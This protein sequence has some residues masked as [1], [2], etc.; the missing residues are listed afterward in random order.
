MTKILKILSDRY[1]RDSD[2]LNAQIRQELSVFPL[3]LYYT[4]F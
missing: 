1:V 4:D 2:P 3:P